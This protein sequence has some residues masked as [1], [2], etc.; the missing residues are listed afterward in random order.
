MIEDQNHHADGAC[1]HRDLDPADGAVGN[2][3]TL[4][5]IGLAKNQM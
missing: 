4:K 1:N 3:D 5:Q 2:T